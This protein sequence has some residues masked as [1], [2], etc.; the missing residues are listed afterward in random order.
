MS[1]QPTNVE[2]L[3]KLR[4]IS[5]HK[6]IRAFALKCGKHEATMSSYLSG[7]LTPGDKVL[8]DC[9]VNVLG[10]NVEPLMELMKIPASNKIPV[11]PGVYVIYDSGAQV[12]YIGKATNFRTEISQTLS[13]KIPVPLRFGPTLKKGNPQIKE[14][15][16]YLSLYAV[17][18][19][20]I[21][22]NLEVLLL[23]VFANQMHNSNV[24]K[25]K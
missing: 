15:A 25:Y 11:V 24:G 16:T 13:R 4:T 19:P 17:P 9:F 10:W 2:V 22:H 7:Q 14:L 6:Q 5:G 20:K 1:R 3:N 12:L 8:R 18:S 21:R 23:R